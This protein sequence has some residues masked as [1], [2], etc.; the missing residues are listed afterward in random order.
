MRSVRGKYAGCSETLRNVFIVP[1]RRG[2]TSHILCFPYARL[3]MFPVYTRCLYRLYAPTYICEICVG[4]QLCVFVYTVVLMQRLLR[5]ICSLSYASPL[6]IIWTSL[7]HEISYIHVAVI[8]KNCYISELRP[9]GDPTWFFTSEKLHVSWSFGN[10]VTA[11]KFLLFE[12]NA[13][14][15]TSLRAKKHP[16]RCG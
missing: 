16:A 1:R 4:G 7:V 12:L 14:I 10:V 5:S 2:G 11:I 3:F 8:R 13:T 9:H 15:N 6:P